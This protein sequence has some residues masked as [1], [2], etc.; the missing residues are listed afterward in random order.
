MELFETNIG[1]IRMVVNERCRRQR[2]K[3]YLGDSGGRQRNIL[4]ELPRSSRRVM[5]RSSFCQSGWDEKSRKCS[6]GL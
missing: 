3:L 5:G 6:L 4:I 2:F 1:P